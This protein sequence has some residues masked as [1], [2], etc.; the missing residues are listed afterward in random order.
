MLDSNT[1]SEDAITDRAPGFASAL[2]SALSVSPAGSIGIGPASREFLLLSLPVRHSWLSLMP[3]LDCELD[4]LDEPDGRCEDVGEV[5][6]GLDEKDE[7]VGVV[8]VVEAVGEHDGEVGG[9]GASPISASTVE[10]VRTLVGIVDHSRRAL[11]CLLCTV[12]CVGFLCV[13][14]VQSMH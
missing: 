3:T 7:A 9:S 2:L 4:G 5:S 8:G 14:R 12:V 6:A 1:L 10:V 13:F 11:A